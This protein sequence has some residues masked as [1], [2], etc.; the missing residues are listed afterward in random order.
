MRGPVVYCLEAADLSAGTPL[1]EIHLPR[2]FAPTAHY[3]ADLLGGVTV[4][5]GTAS[6]S[7]A[8]PGDTSSIAGAAP[9][10]AC[11]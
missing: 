1:D 8:G 4:L 2:V 3:A 10:S 9:G 11:R 7:G 6:G 5:E